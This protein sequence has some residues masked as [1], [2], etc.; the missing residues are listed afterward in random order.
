MSNLGLGIV[1]T[2]IMIPLLL[3]LLAVVAV[4]LFVRNKVDILPSHCSVVVD[5]KSMF[6]GLGLSGDI[7]RIGVIGTFLIC[8]KAY[9]KRN[10]IDEAQVRAFSFKLKLL[11]VVPWIIGLVLVILMFAFRLWLYVYDRYPTR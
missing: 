5:N 9:L 2:A 6:A 8:R 7:V 3:D 10:V 1:A 11:I 4:T